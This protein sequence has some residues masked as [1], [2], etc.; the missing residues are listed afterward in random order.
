MAKI[1]SFHKFV[2]S[3][4]KKKSK[5]SSDEPEDGKNKTQD[6]TQEKKPEQ[7]D[8]KDG[9]DKKP[10]FGKDEKSDKTKTVKDDDKKEGTPSRRKASDPASSSE[11]TLPGRQDNGE[12]TDKAGKSSSVI[13]NPTGKDLEQRLDETTKRS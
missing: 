6:K 12:K 11:P 8:D 5:P 7:S 10:A 2:E 1:P 4:S 3:E 9:K 13:I